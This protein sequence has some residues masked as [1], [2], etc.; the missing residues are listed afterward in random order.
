MASTGTD[1]KFVHLHVHSSYSLLE[2][3]LP[4]GRQVAVQ[5]GCAFGAAVYT[6]L[7]SYGLARAVDALVGLRIEELGEEQGLDLYQHGESGYNL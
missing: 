6:A 3:A 5:L 7:V 4:I 2:G 1:P